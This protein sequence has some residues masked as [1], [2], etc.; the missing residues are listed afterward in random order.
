[1]HHKLLLSLI[2]TLFL[3]TRLY[4]ITTIPSSLYW[5]EASIGYNAYSVL[6]TGKDEWGKMFPVHFRAFG[7]FK[8]P[9]YIYSV[10]LTEVFFGLSEF[11]VR[12][13]A[14]LFSLSSVLLIY[15]FCKQ[16]YKTEKL[17]LLAAFFLTITPWFFI[18]SRTGYEVNAGLFFYLLGLV[19]FLKIEKSHKY[20][21]FFTLAEILSMYSYNSFRII[22]PITYFVLLLY[23]LY[24]N[25]KLYEKKNSII[26]I[27]LLIFLVS[28]LPIIR[29]ITSNEGNSR[30]EAIRVENYWSIPGNYLGHF[31]TN[32]L[33]ISGDKNLRSSMPGFGELYFMQFPLIVLGF[34]LSIKRYVK[35][36]NIK[37]LLPFFILILGPIPA[38]ITKESPHALR[39]LVM[40][41]P[42]VIF[43]ALGSSLILEKFKYKYLAHILIA[44]FLL[45]YGIYVYK[46]YINYNIIA[47]KDWQYP[48]KIINTG[49][50]SLVKDYPE[51]YISD[52]LAQPY[53]FVLFYEKINPS[54][55]K[56]NV[57][58]NSPDKWG[59]STVSSFGKYHFIEV[60]KKTDF[61]KN[62]LI[63]STVPLHLNQLGVIKNF[64]TTPA[65]YA[66]TN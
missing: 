21:L 57:S 3:I 23:W 15:F 44:M 53:I 16:L 1:M 56:M 10:S 60:E 45:I 28:L 59:F 46:F 52:R 64:D 42:L 49:Y 58:Y 40:V 8:L 65:I 7:E 43:A 51:V 13:P 63:F 30:F 39:S 55:F 31:K 12:L 48:Y 41:I 61:D 62:S 6:T 66:Y 9:V 38:S 18:F 25:K 36:R 22:T 4:Q 20:F 24:K 54:S 5:D 37:V 50:S 27:S 14:V 19:F 2:L 11:S 17:G 26:V 47:S 32:F 35:G 33:F 29:M 34:I